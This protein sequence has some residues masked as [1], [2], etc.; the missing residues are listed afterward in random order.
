MMVD[1]FIIP[2]F[3]AV[4]AMGPGSGVR[5]GAGS[6]GTVAGGL[7]LLAWAAAPG[8]LG[9]ASGV[10]GRSCWAAIGIEKAEGNVPFCSGFRFDMRGGEGSLGFEEG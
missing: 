3:P 2:P 9:F 5:A 10:D 4:V 6:C 7:A 1:A 8:G